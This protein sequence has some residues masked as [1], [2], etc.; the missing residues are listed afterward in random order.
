MICFIE[1]LK[2]IHVLIFLPLILS[3]TLGEQIQPDVLEMGSKFDLEKVDFSENVEKLFSKQISIGNSS[4]LEYDSLMKGSLI[5][6]KTGIMI[7]DLID[8]FS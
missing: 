6:S 5:T 7:Q 4:Y 1:N 3:C 8:K 2:Y